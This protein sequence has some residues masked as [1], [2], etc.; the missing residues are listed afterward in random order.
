M[1]L[2]TKMKDKAKIF[3]VKALIQQNMFG[4]PVLLSIGKFRNSVII[5]LFH[6]LLIIA[7]V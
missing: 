5:Y 4:T 7:I 3:V 1:A 6:G 2:E